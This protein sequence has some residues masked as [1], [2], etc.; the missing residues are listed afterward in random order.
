MIGKFLLA[1]LVAYCLG[2]INIAIIG[3]NLLFKKDIRHFG[4]N[5]AGTTNAY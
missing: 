3:S 4:S 5:N 2:N 1:A